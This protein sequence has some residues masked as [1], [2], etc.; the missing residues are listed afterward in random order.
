MREA[1]AQSD[2]NNDGMQ[3][4]SSKGADHKNV[5]AY[6][7]DKQ[8]LYDD[9]H[10]DAILERQNFLVAFLSNKKVCGLSFEPQTTPGL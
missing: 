4:M 2:A 6:Y 7:E 1:K 8:K 5:L 3:M 10:A 9:T